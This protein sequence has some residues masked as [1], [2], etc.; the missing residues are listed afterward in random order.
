M[1]ASA[2]FALEGSVLEGVPAKTQHNL[3][4][5]WKSALGED[6]PMILFR[7]GKAKP[8]PMVTGRQVIDHYL[9]QE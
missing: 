9:E 4:E 5:G 2:I 7:I 8:L 1:P 6:I 3:A